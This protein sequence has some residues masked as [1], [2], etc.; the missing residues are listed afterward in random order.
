[1]L[2]RW[3]GPKKRTPSSRVKQLRLD[4][5]QR[6]SSRLRRRS[7]RS[8]GSSDRRWID[9]KQKKQ[10]ESTYNI[11]VFQ[12]MASE[13]QYLEVKASGRKHSGD[14]SACLLPRQF[15]PAGLQPQ[16][17]SGHSSTARFNS[18]TQFWSA[19]NRALQT[20]RRE[21]SFP[22]ALL[23]SFYFPRRFLSPS[24]ISK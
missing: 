21:R 3:K 8:P 14:L 20:D 16:W 1:M 7:N 11:T 12:R 23:A 6:A 9:G 19:L 17:S 10:R 13:A 18:L 4:S 15:A 22:R 2:Q 24:D 5:G